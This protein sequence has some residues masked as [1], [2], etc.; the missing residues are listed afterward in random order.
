MV[1]LTLNCI[2]RACLLYGSRAKKTNR[3]VAIVFDELWLLAVIYLN[4]LSK[5]IGTNHSS[6][7]ASQCNLRL[8]E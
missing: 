1:F 3:M 5:N 6:L 4:D 2:R 7:R 8:A